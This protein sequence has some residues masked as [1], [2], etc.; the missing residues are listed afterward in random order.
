MTSEPRPEDSLRQL[1]RDQWW[2]LALGAMVYLG[3]VRP[4]FGITADDAFISFRYA[5]NWAAGCGP[6][7]NCGQPPVEGYTNFL[8]TALGALVISLGLPVVETMRLVGLVCGLAMV[9]WAVLLCRQVHRRRAAQIA[10][11]AAI[12]ACPF[13]AVN[14]VVGLETAAATLSVL[15]AAQLSLTLPDGKRPWIPGLAWGVSYLIRPEA[16]GLAALTGIFFFTGGLVRRLGLRRTL[17][18]VLVY[19]VGFVV[20]AGPYFIWRLVY[21]RDLLPNTFYAKHVPLPVLLPRNLRLIADSWTYFAPLLLVAVAAVVLSRK[22]RQLYLLLL[23]LA[24]EAV[25]LSVH[26]NFWMPGH[27]LH[28][29]SAALLLVVAA[30]VVDLRLGQRRWV[31]AAAL[32]GLCAVLLCACWFAYPKTH[33]LAHLH[34]ARDDHPAM[35]MGLAIRRWARPGDW[36]AIRDAGMVPFYAG[37]AVNVLDMHRHSLND[38]RIT[39]EGWDLGYIMSHKPR[40]IVFASV[41]GGQLVYTHPEERAIADS[42]AFRAA[43]YR[44]VMRTAWHRIRHF[45]LFRRD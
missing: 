23:A 32:G 25:A 6:V 3:A 36:L 45:F 13:F 38:R 17:R 1:A 29:T 39:R 12:A 18:G 24:A 34:Y 27:R 44:L 21:Y 37:P 43:G 31:G 5:Q 22:G 26:N 42:P 16:M 14:A 35:K 2:V 8:W 19:A 11:V 4:F 40:F 7:Y 15:V 30:G 28:L 9:G 33:E 41:H 20:V 10:P